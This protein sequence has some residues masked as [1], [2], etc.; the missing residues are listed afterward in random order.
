L[1]QPHLF[2]AI[3]GAT[4]KGQT[5]SR[6]RW[7]ILQSAVLAALLLF[8]ALKNLDWPSFW[9]TLSNAKY[10][11]LPVVLVWSSVSYFIRALRWRVLLSAEKPI[12]QLNAFLANMTGYLGNN[13]LPARAGELV[14]ALYANRVAGLSLP[15]ALAVGLSERLMDVIVLI[16]LGSIS[17]SISGI[18]S[19]LFQQAIQAVAIL[20]GA[21]VIVFL[22]LPRF[23]SSLLKIMSGI[24]FLSLNAKEKIS[25][26][27][28]KFLLGLRTLL[29]LKRAVAFSLY[30]VFIWL[31]DGLCVVLIGIMLHISITLVQAF[32]LL[33][34]LGLSSAIPS[35]PGY[36]GVYQFV[37]ITVLAPFGI[38]QA[39]ALAFI[40]TSQMLGYMVI[41]FWGLMGL[42]RYGR[43][44]NQEKE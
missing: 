11:L 33:S 43:I 40:L 28:E 1:K 25:S 32:L 24:P 31:M 4:P 5:G 9:N 30:T 38:T 42:W 15:F 8:L 16:L 26:F 6:S 36:V 2:N 34:G 7:I 3:L 20:A 21:G 23:S 39:D 22:L 27:L 13:I 14:R 19:G 29:H 17:L 44:V 41:F 35:T 12:S 18:A 37:A 10:T